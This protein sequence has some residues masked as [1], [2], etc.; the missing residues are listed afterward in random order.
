M[1]NLSIGQP[2]HLNYNSKYNYTKNITG[3]V[4]KVKVRKWGNSLGVV[5]PKETVKEKNVKAGDEVYAE[6]RKPSDI[7]KIFG[8]LKEWK[9]DTQE[10]KDEA[11]QGWD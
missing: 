1:N 2:K 9:R 6:I 10:I 4:L 8:S 3:V 5:I 11:R 7:K